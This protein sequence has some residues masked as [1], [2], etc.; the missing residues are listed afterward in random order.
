MFAICKLGDWVITF[1]LNRSMFETTFDEFNHVKIDVVSN[2]CGKA[3]SGLILPFVTDIK[4][5]LYYVLTLRNN[6][7]HSLR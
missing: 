4:T 2:A 1:K 5:N 3:I 6:K 7:I